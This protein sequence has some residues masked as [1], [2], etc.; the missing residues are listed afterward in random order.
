MSTRGFIARIRAIRCGVCLRRGLLT[1]GAGK[2]RERPR[3]PRR[4]RFFFRGALPGGGAGKPPHPPPPPRRAPPR[5]PPRDAKRF[6]PPP[7]PHHDRFTPAEESFTTADV[8]EQRISALDR[9]DR[10]EPHR[11]P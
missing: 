6:H 11:H 4:G 5:K 8:E 7:P 3:R 2:S 10:R 1:E 9:N